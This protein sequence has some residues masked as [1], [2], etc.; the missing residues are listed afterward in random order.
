MIL[1]TFHM[2]ATPIFCIFRPVLFSELHIY[3]PSCLFETSWIYLLVCHP[4]SLQLETQ[5]LSFTSSSFTICVHN[6]THLSVLSHMLQSVPH[7]SFS[8]VAMSSYVSIIS[9]FRSL[10]SHLS[11]S[12]LASSILHKPIRMVF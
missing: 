3:T 12:T 4:E 5:E 9:H 7:L 10:L 8:T 1:N 11:V 2:L 6:Q